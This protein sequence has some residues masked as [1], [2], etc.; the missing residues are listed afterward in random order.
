MGNV[1]FLGNFEDVKTYIA[2]VTLVT[3]VC[4]TNTALSALDLVGHIM[5]LFHQTEDFP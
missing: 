1:T 2:V 4:A 3:L 5:E